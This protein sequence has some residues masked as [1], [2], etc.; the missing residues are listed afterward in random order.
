MK[1]IRCSNGHFYDTDANS[2]CPHCSA[3]GIS[4]KDSTIALPP[5]PPAQFGPPAPD[6][7]KT[8]PQRRAPEGKTKPIEQNGGKDEK[9]IG[10]FDKAGIDPVVGWLVCVEGKNV[11]KDYRLKVGSNKI[12]RSSGM[13]VAIA[14]DNSVAREK[15]AA[16][17]FE[18]HRLQFLVQAGD[19]R[20]L[21]YLNDEVVLTPTELQ[22]YDI[23]TLGETKLAFVPL[24]SERFSWPNGKKDSAQ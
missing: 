21:C 15:H 18:P 24:C 19:A 1:L 11:G 14:D 4:P 9:T 16:I 22:P 5:Q 2:R 17:I 8:V 6:W 13:D 20:E 3:A 7:G 23:L 12:G 10:I